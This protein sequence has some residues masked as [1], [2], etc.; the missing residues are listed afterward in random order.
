MS[1]APGGEQKSSEKSQH[2]HY[3]LA[4][5]KDRPATSE[6]IGLGHGAKRLSETS[7]W[8]VAMYTMEERLMLGLLNADDAE[9]ENLRAQYRNLQQFQAEMTE[10]INRAESLSEELLTD[11][12]R[13]IAR[14]T[15]EAQVAE[16][17]NK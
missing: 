11:Q 6:L 9:V 17:W 7:A 1:K 14:R 5:I 12:E 8:L 16:G 4:L 2:A 15:Q 10:M 3:G 13:V